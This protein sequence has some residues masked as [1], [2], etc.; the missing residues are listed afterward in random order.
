[1]FSELAT[2]LPKFLGTKAQVHCFT[3]TV[4]LTAKGVLCPFEPVKPAAGKSNAPVSPDGLDELYAKLRD[5]EENG[6]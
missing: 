4:N 5:I 6:D 2:I 3:H 1:M